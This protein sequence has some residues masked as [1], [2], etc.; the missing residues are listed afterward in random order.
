MAGRR[1]GD[2]VESVAKTEGIRK[3]LDW[4]PEFDDLDTIV[5][6]AWAWERR[7]AEWAR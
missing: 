5:A 2:V 7:H 1:E 3:T 6:H 4:A